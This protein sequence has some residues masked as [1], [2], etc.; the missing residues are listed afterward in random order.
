M[1]NKNRVVE[2]SVIQARLKTAITH[3]VF[4]HFCP[5]YVKEKIKAIDATLPND[6]YILR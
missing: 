3:P 4:R 2:W 5:D 1:V 6:D